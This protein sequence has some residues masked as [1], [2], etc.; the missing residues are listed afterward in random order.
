MNETFKGL[1]VIELATVLAGPT[2]GMFFAEL[3][4]EV[5]KIENPRLGGDITRKWKLG[6][7]DSEKD[8][9]AYFC[10]VNWGKQ[11]VFAD[12]KTE[13]G[14]QQ[15]HNLVKDADIVLSNF[16]AGDDVKLQ[17]DPEMLLAI[18]PDLIIGKISG[19]GNESSR[20]AF[21][22]VLQAEAGYMFMNGQPGS[23]PSKMPVALI[24][25][26][27]AHQLKEALLIAL[28]HKEKTGNGSVVS[29]SLFDAA[30][31]ALTNQASNWLMAGHIP[32]Q[33]GSLHP[34]IAPYGEILT[35]ADG[36]RIV[37]A[38]GSAGQLLGLCSVLNLL[39]LISD[40]RF[41]TEQSRVEN[42]E[43]L[44]K[45]L[46]AKASKINGKDL[47]DQFLKEGVPAGE[48]RNMEQVF[49]QEAAQKLVKEEIMSDG[50]ISNRVSDIAFKIW[51]K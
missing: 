18:K 24:D 51:E 49:E 17:M 26:L 32:K 16:R 41:A 22:V 28:L 6:S 29:V 7:E 42:R 3:G 25:V 13:E 45:L 50:T 37:L 4:A 46:S 27:A 44:F 1:R 8:Y 9:S 48:I 47:L 36:T 10:S 15:V 23:D 31:S 12:L 40:Q 2:V 34:N 11:H 14:K 30:V 38:I 20:P 43:E 39:E 35:C 19:Y 33:M 21:D 5:I